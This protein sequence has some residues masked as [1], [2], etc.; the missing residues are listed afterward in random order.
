MNICMHA[1]V[2]LSSS[3]EKSMSESLLMV[4]EREQNVRMCTSF[5]VL[6]LKNMLYIASLVGSWHH[7]ESIWPDES[8]DGF[9]ALL[10]GNNITNHVNVESTYDSFTTSPESPAFILGV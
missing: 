9:L 3:P 10:S 1:G 6:Y 8:W 4:G 5:S 7:F 2:T